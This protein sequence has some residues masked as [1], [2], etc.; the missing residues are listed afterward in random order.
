MSAVQARIYYA[1][2]QEFKLLAGIIRDYTP[3]E[4]TYDPDVGDVS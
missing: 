2:K 4:Y 3:E 1:M